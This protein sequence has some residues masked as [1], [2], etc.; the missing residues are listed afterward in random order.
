MSYANLDVYLDGRR[1]R[2][3]GLPSSANPWAAG[4]VYNQD[5]L[6]GWQHG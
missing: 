5:W 3:E 4:T 6:E 2:R 1:A